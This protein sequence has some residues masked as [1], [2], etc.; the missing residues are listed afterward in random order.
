MTNETGYTTFAMQYWYVILTLCL[1]VVAI[2]VFNIIVFIYYSKHEP[3]EPN[4]LFS[5]LEKQHKEENGQDEN[6]NDSGSEE[7]DDRLNQILYHNSA[8]DKNEEAPMPVIADA[9]LPPRSASNDD[10]DLFREEAMQIHND[11]RTDHGVHPLLH[12]EEL[13]IY[14]QYWAEELAKIDQ[15]KHSKMEWRMKCKNERLGE[16]VIM[17]KGIKLNG[18]NAVNMWY[19]ES[20][21]HRYQD[22]QK[23]S[24]AFSQMIWAGSEQVGFGRAK[25]RTGAWYGTALYYPE[26]NITGTFRENVFPRVIP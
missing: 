15:L 14:A 21:K 5:D 22:Y 7:E 4:R 6:E 9:I 1:G 26:G 13:A 17:T 12:S 3:I 19:S 8:F 2:I 10:L 16:N 20:S 24:S 18:K 25:S 11:Y 23:E